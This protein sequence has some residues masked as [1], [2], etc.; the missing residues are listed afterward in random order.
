MKVLKKLKSCY[1]QILASKATQR[2]PKEANI[3][4]EKIKMEVS[5]LQNVSEKDLVKWL[6]LKKKKTHNIYYTVVYL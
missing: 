3:S 5:G 4:K 6:F 2:H 1:S